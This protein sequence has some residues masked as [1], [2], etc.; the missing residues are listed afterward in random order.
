MCRDE[1]TKLDEGTFSHTYN[2]KLALSVSGYSSQSIPSARKTTRSQQ[3]ADARKNHVSGSPKQ[4]MIQEEEIASDCS[5][6]RAAAE[7]SANLAKFDELAKLNESREGEGK[8]DISGLEGNT[9]TSKRRSNAMRIT[10]SSIEAEPD[11]CADLGDTREKDEIFASRTQA[12]QKESQIQWVDPKE[13]EERKKLAERL[14]RE[15]QSIPEEERYQKVKYNK[16][17]CNLLKYG[18]LFG[19]LILVFP[20]QT[21]DSMDM[22]ENLT[23]ELE[24]R[25]HSQDEIPPRPESSEKRSMA[26]EPKTDDED[27][28]KENDQSTNSKGSSASSGK[29]QNSYPKIFMTSG[30][31][32]DDQ[33][34]FA[35]FL[36]SIEVEFNSGTSCEP[37]VTHLIAQK[38]ARSEKMLGSVAS[39]KWLLHPSYISDCKKEG[40][41]LPEES[42]EWGNPNNDLVNDLSTELEVK[43]AKAAHRLRIRREKGLNQVFGGIKAIIHSN[44]QRKGSF[45]KLLLSG[46]G[47]II[48]N[49]KPPYSDPKGATHCIAEPHKLPQ[50]SIDYEALAMRGVA[51]VNPVYINEFLSACGTDDQQSPSVDDHLIDAFKPHWIQRRKH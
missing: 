42:Y 45:K 49:S 4:P 9:S 8:N 43:L 16:N 47:T 17:G 40:K 51:C 13:E 36:Q 35:S 19:C 14:A 48:E 5:T 33:E 12:P 28:D 30:I 6:S 37:S 11:R 2:P 24:G 32:A 46:G 39:G 1:N 44:E 31:V 27:S 41:L 38:V 18:K 23:E 20:L 10:L 26:T 25:L 22:P 15:T 3:N 7:L 29:K 34:S 50:I 21:F